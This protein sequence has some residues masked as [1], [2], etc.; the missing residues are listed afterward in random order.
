MKLNLN[1]S[2]LG[3][4]QWLMILG[5]IAIA[6]IGAL[7]ILLAP[8]QKAGDGHAKEGGHAH[9]EE[10]GHGEHAEAPKGPHGGELLREGDFGLEV[11]LQEEGG[12]ARLRVWFYEK[13]KPL[14][15]SAAKLA[16]SLM[17]PDGEKEDISFLADK[18][19]LRSVQSI[20]EPHAFEGTIE[21]QTPKEPYLFTFS[22]DE[23]RIALSEEQIKAAN[24]S[25]DSAA[26]ASIRNALQL[27]GEIR[28]NQDRTAHVVPRV[29]GVV[30]RVHA[31]L[32]QA[33][34]KGALLAVIAST[35]VSEL[36]SEQLATQ[37]RLGLAKATY[38]REKKLWEEKITP[39]QDYLQAEQ[40][41]REAEIAANNALQKLAALGAGALS[42][43]NLSRFELRAPFAGTV[44]EK[45]ITLGESVKEDAQLF[46]LS[47]LSQ[48]WAEI[49]VPAK[50]MNLVRVGD[51]V[52]ISATAFESQATGTVSYVGALIGEQTRTASAR[53]TLPNPQGAWRPGLFVNVEL[54]ASETPVPVSIAAE[55]V[56]NINE[57]PTVFLR[58]ADGFLAQP[59][60]LG[61]SD[62]KRVEVIKGVKAGA[63]YAAASSFVIK[64]ELGKSSAAH[65]H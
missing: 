21:A 65:E 32:G 25:V 63:R 33:V 58:T 28:F 29:Q 37:K 18:D 27:P 13:D 47:D 26:P 11:A 5:L 8:A 35:A 4:R 3:K 7:L 56:Q 61:R 17:R 45:H 51:K 49:S 14:P 41:L 1:T 59:V 39:Q 15:A 62:G 20:A 30:E 34:S 43:N 48:V 44:V 2:S 12:E 38:E 22:K 55:A 54:T 9:E 10:A 60:Q 6:V 40:A 19:G 42:G 23:G 64:A 53:V 50:D 57:R 36:R 52:K 16:V 46:I 31:D 24:I